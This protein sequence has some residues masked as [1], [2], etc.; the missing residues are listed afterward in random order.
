[1]AECL[2]LYFCL[3]AGFKLKSK[4]VIVDCDLL[5]QLPDQPF[6]VVRYLCCLIR[7][8]GFEVVQPLL[9]ACAVGFFDQQVLFFLCPYC[10]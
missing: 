6:V 4:V 8:K 5:D 1:M 10:P 2:H 9:H 7:Q 3:K